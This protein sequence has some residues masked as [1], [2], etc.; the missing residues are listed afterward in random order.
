[1]NLSRREEE[2]NGVVDVVDAIFNGVVDAIFIII[3]RIRLLIS[4]T[5]QFIL[6]A[7]RI[8]VALL[9]Q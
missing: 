2:I 9:C 3:L 1:M 6:L 7:G 4:H 5:V 8:A